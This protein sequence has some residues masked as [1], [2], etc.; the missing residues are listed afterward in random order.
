MLCCAVL[1][2]RLS[3][4]ALADLCVARQLYSSTLMRI[5]QQ[6]QLLVLQLAQLISDAHSR[7][8]A[9]TYR[10]DAIFQS[11]TGKQ[12]SLTA[13]CGSALQLAGLSGFPCS[14]LIVLRGAPCRE[15]MLLSSALPHCC[16]EEPICMHACFAD[17][18]CSWWPFF[19]AGANP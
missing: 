7:S 6:R 3:P 13:T 9:L 11:V 16:C 4:Q 12:C 19:R 5:K 14:V 10:T 8:P 17:S 2:C 1:C 15:L 18:Q